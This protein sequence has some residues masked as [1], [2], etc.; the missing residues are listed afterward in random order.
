VLGLL[1]QLARIVAQR[2]LMLPLEQLRARVS[3]I[4]PGLGRGVTQAGG[5]LRLGIAKLGAQR[6]RFLL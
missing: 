2:E 3:L 4:V 6:D 5:D 1:K